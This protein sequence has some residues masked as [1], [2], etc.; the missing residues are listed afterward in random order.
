MG[1]GEEFPCRIDPSRN[2]RVLGI[3]SDEFHDF[4]GGSV[5]LAYRRRVLDLAEYQLRKALALEVFRF[6]FRIRSAHGN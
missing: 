2:R 5:G 3:G 6:L 1:W 4:C